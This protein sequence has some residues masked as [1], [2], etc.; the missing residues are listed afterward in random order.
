M[1]LCS[2]GH[3]EVCFETRECPACAAIGEKQSEIDDMKSELKEVKAE[4][5]DL[6][7]ALAN[8]N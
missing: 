4:R 8:H 2:D 6:A 1:D 7:K 5:D 3:E